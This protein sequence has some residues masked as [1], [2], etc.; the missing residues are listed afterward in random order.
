M[1]QQQKR[2]YKKKRKNYS[3]TKEKLYLYEV[4][5]WRNKTQVKAQSEID[6]ISIA[7][8][9]QKVGAWEWPEATLLTV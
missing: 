6:A 8:K 5:G 4:K 7:I 9:S 2:F 1:E 3:S